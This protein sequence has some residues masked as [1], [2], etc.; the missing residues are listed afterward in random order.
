V[1]VFLFK[2]SVLASFLVFQLFSFPLVFYLLFIV[3]VV[4]GKAGGGGDERTHERELK[5][6]LVA[7]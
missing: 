1:Q 3:Y 7:G 5:N 6:L 2:F 4:K